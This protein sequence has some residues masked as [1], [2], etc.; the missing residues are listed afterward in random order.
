MVYKKI[1]KNPLIILL[2]GIISGCS[3]Q[4][5]T[6][7]DEKNDDCGDDC[8][9]S[10]WEV[11][12]A[13]GGVQINKYLGDSEDVTIP[14]M[15]NGKKVVSIG[16]YTGSRSVFY[17]S[18]EKIESIDMSKAIYLTTIEN[19]A[20]Y[21]CEK[22]EE[23]ELPNSI[24]EIKSSAFYNCKS[25]EEI[26]FPKN[27]ISI[28]ENAFRNCINITKI[29]IKRETTP[30]TTCYESKYS[31]ASNS[32]YGSEVYKDKLEK[33]VIYYPKGTNYKSKEGWSKLN[34]KWKER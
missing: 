2:L 21:N 6:I 7:I 5:G 18:I 34:A 15:I 17:N 31:D 4:G 25:L 10:N 19:S 24:K 20:F 16:Y 27:L 3:F 8:S 29:T 14:E 32:F 28:G 22:L 23:V 26:E 33:A 12:I 1:N 9:S 13:T 30:L 11:S